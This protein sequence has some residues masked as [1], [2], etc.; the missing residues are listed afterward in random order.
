VYNWNIFCAWT[1][2]MHTQIHKTH[3][4]SNLGEATTFPFIVFF[5]IN[6]RG[7]TQ[8]SFCPRTPKMGML[9]FLKLRFLKLWRHV[10]SYANL[11]LR[12][13]LN[14][15]CNFRQEFSKD[16]WH[17]TYTHIIQGD[18]WFLVVRNQ[19]GTLIRNPSFGHNLCYKYSNGS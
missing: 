18:Y 11:Q 3:H 12:W 8:M 13:D 5:V 17:T 6:H 14:Q 9:K 15:S 1:S 16:M 7:Y 10:T 2:R 19:I 4:G